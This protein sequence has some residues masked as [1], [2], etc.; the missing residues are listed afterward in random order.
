MRFEGVNRE[1]KTITV[2]SG[3]EMNH[4]TNF[5][6]EIMLVTV[7]ASGTHNGTHNYHCPTK[8]YGLTCFV[9]DGENFEQKGQVSL[10]S[11]VIQLY[12]GWRSAFKSLLGHQLRFSVFFSVP[13]G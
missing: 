3:N 5:V 8:S 9:E 1:S 13:P 4:Y 2:Y 6:S 11:D 7:K 10:I 12:L